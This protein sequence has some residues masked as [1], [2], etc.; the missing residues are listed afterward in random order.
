M[1]SPDHQRRRFIAKTVTVGCVLAVPGILSG[2]GGEEAQTLRETDS[3]DSATTSSNTGGGADE[4]AGT[5]NQRQ[6]THT[7]S[8]N[9]QTESSD[10]SSGSGS[11]ADEQGG[12]VS[13]EQANYKKQPNGQEKCSNCQHFV[14]E[15]NTCKL[16][17]G[18]ISPNGWCKLWVA[19]A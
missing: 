19:N 9:Q 6:Q 1:P 10:K 15:S 2:C 16:V 8:Q 4:Q 12:K 14:S 7:D 17:Q 5:G 18:Q 13:Q 11:Q 3:D